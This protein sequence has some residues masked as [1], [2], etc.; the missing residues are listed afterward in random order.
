MGGLKGRT[1]IAGREKRLVIE[2]TDIG[3]I[4]VTRQTKHNAREC[5]AAIFVDNLCLVDRL[6]RRFAGPCSIFHN[7]YQEKK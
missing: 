2:A 1:M 7:F 4:A 6:R 5:G 3:V